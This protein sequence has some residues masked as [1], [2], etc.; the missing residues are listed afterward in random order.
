[1]IVTGFRYLLKLRSSDVIYDPLP[2][3]HT[4]GGLLGTLPSL[5]YGLTVVIKAKFSASNY[6]ADCVKY[7]C[8]V[9]ITYDGI[10]HP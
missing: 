9:S 4:A 7:K 2:L 5:A 8:T 6:F 10:G 3:Y 1:M